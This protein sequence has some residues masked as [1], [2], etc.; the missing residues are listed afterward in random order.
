MVITDTPT[1]AFEN[2]SMDIVG[3]LPEIKSGKLFIVT[4]Q[5]NFTKYC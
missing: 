4:K 2:I 3:L 1:T 5:D